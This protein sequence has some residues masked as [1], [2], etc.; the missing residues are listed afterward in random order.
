LGLPAWVWLGSLALLP[1]G[2]LLAAGR[3]RGLGH[4]VVGG[5]LVSATGSLVRRR[6]VLSCEGIIGWNLRQSFF[7]RFRGRH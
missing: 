4:A 2:A 1:C 3:Y 6:H 5:G 7:Q